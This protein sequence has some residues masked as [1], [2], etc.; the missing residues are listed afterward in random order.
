LNS[1]MT[2]GKAFH[3]RAPA[4]IWFFTGSRDISE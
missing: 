4:A 2:A 3:I 1:L